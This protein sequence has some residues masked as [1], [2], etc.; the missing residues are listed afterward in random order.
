MSPVDELWKE[1]SETKSTEIK[2]QLTLQYTNLVHYVITH[3]SLPQHHM[4]ESKDLFQ[5]GIEGLYEA[6]DRF[7]P[8]YGTKFETYALQR[9]RGKVI[10]E[11]RK[12]TTKGNRKEANEVELS[13]QTYV[14]EDGLQLIETIPSEEFPSPQTNAETNETRKALVKAISNLCERDRLVLTLYYYENL[15]YQEITQVM[16]VSVSRISQLHSRILKY[17]KSELE[18]VTNG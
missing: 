1:F 11:V 3:T 7:D 4:I 9:I 6:I 8:S 16:N 18:G 2:K 12:I 13:T 10:D 15:N 17:L 14:D 5:F